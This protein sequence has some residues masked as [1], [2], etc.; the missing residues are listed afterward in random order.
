MF[1]SYRVSVVM[2]TYNGSRFIDEQ[3]ASI[4]SQ[5]FPIYELIIV[6]DFSI[7]DTWQKLEHWR[8]T[9]SSIK[10]FRNDANLGYNKN[11]EYAIQLAKGDLIAISD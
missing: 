1:S 3:I 9:N 8:K 5:D 4:L 2:C 11:F 6:D 7:D 10:I